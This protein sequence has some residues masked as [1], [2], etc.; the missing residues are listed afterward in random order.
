MKIYRNALV[1]DDHQLFASALAGLIR[2]TGKFEG[3]FCTDKLAEVQQF[4]VSNNISHFFTDYIMP[5]V[6]TLSEIAKIKSEYPDIFITVISS[7]KNANLVFQMHKAGADSFLSKNSDKYELEECLSIMDT[8]KY[9]VSRD[10]RG[11]MMN[12]LASGKEKLLTQ[13]ENEI[14]Q[15]IAHGATIEETAKKLFL[16]KHTVVAHRR[17]IMAKL[18]VNSVT[19]LLKKAMDLGLI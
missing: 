6:N 13:R 18:E 8:G 7:I 3:V 14:L 19:V 1:L 2:E 12:F 4:L 5:D 15:H 11:P 10:M 16:S 9:F 17:N